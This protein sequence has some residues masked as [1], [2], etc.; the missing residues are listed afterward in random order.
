MNVELCVTAIWN[1]V[2]NYHYHFNSVSLHSLVS[3]D[4]SGNVRDVF[5]NDNVNF[6]YSRYILQQIFVL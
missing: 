3:S 2:I 6:R 4:S 5:L 1:G